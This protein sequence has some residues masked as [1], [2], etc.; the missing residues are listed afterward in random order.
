M[1]RNLSLIFLC[2]FSIAFFGC[3]DTGSTVNTNNGNRAVAKT[4]VPKATVDEL[5]SGKSAYELNCMVCHRSDGTGGKVTVEGRSLNVDDLTSAKI[6][7][8]S[9][10]KIIGYM[11]KG[12][13]SEGMPAFKDKISEGEMRDI[14]K[15][16]RTEFQK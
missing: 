2:G 12:I 11:I 4:P 15:F 5:A 14:V 7:A 16:I 6:K 9:D 1:T 3:G 13:P 8:F 10:E